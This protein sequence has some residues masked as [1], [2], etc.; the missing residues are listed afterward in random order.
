MARESALAQL[1]EY[2]ASAAGFVAQRPAPTASARATARPPAAHPQRTVA[3]GVDRAREAYPA[4]TARRCACACAWA[5]ASA[6]ASREPSAGLFG[7]AMRGTQRESCRTEQH[8]HARTATVWGMAPPEGAVTSC[9]LARTPSCADSPGAKLDLLIDRKLR[10]LSGQRQ[11]PSPASAASSAR[12]FGE[13]A[14]ADA[15]L[16]LL[17]PPREDAH[18]ERPPTPDRL[19]ARY[20]AAIRPSASEAPAH[21]AA[22]GVGSG[23]EQADAAPFSLH[24]AAALPVSC[25]A[26]PTGGIATRWA[27]APPP[28]G[29]AD[30]S[31]PAAPAAARAPAGVWVP[32][33]AC[34]WLDAPRVCWPA[35]AAGC[36][37]A[38]AAHTSGAAAT[39]MLTTVLT[40]ASL[41]A[42]VRESTDR[43]PSHAPAAAPHACSAACASCFVN[44][45]HPRAP[46]PL[47]THAGAHL[48]TASGVEAIDAP[49]PCIAPAACAPH[50]QCGRAA[51][52]VAHKETA[53]FP[54]PVAHTETA[55]FP[56]PAA[57]TETAPFPHPVAHT[58]TAPFPHPAAHTETAPF[59]HPVAHTET[60]PFPHPVAHKETA[61]FP[62]VAAHKETAPFPHVAAHT[63]TAPFPHVAAHTETA[64]FPREMAT[65]RALAGPCAGWT[66]VVAPAGAAL[67]AALASTAA[68]A[69]F[70]EPREPAVGTDARADAP[71]GEGEGACGLR[72]ALSQAAGVGLARDL[73][74]AAAFAPAHM[75]LALEFGRDEHGSEA[76]QQVAQHPSPQP[77]Q[78]VAQHPSPQPAQQVAQHPSPQSAQQVAQ[79]P[80]PQPAQQV[81][82]HPSPQPAQQVA[83]AAA[84]RA[85]RRASSP[86]SAAAEAAAA[87][88]APAVQ[89]ADGVYWPWPW[90]AH[91]QPAEA[92]SP[93]CAT[94]LSSHA[95]PPLPPPPLPPP[96]PPSCV[97]HP[98]AGAQCA[99]P[100]CAA[101]GAPAHACGRDGADSGVSSARWGMGA[102]LPAPPLQCGGADARSDTRLAPE[103]G[104][105]G[106][107]RT[108]ADASPGASASRRMARVM[109]ASEARTQRE[110]FSRLLFG[111]AGGDV[112]VASRLARAS[113]DP[114][115]RAGSWTAQPSRR[116]RRRRRGFVTA[117][118]GRDFPSSLSP[119]D[120]GEGEG[121]GAAALDF[122]EASACEAS[123][124]ER[125]TTCD[126]SS[127]DTLGGPSPARALG[128][129]ACEAA[130]FVASAPRTPDGTACGA[131][132]VLTAAAA[133]Q[134]PRE[135]APRGAVLQSA[136]DWL[137]ATRAPGQTRGPVLRPER[138]WRSLGRALC[139]QA[140]IDWLL[141][142]P[143]LVTCPARL[144]GARACWRRLAACARSRARASA[145]PARAPDAAPPPTPTRRAL[146]RAR[147]HALTVGVRLLHAARKH[148]RADA[149]RLAGAVGALRW[150]RLCARTHRHCAL[151]DAGVARAR[152]ARD[153]AAQP[154]RAPLEHV[155]LVAGEWLTGGKAADASQTDECPAGLPGAPTPAP[156]P[157]SLLARAGAR[158]GSEGADA[159]CD[160]RILTARAGQAAIGEGRECVARA[161]GQERVRARRAPLALLSS[162]AQRVLVAA[163][164]DDS[165]SDAVRSGGEAC[166]GISACDAPREALR[167]DSEDAMPL[168]S[169]RGREPSARVASEAEP[170]PSSL[171][172]RL[173][174]EAAL[175]AGAAGRSAAEAA[176]RPPARTA[177]VGSGARELARRARAQL[178]AIATEHRILSRGASDNG[179]APGAS[180]AARRRARL[181]R[182]A[183]GC[184]RSPP[185][186][187]RREEETRGEASQAAEPR[188]ADGAVGQRAAR[189]SGGID[190]LRAQLNLL[191]RCIAEPPASAR[192]AAAVS[193]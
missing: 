15:A 189:S 170:P 41:G 188:E 46:Q 100:E 21:S 142:T 50:A 115:P 183:L 191:K 151:A 112:D 143:R 65:S 51:H 131:D 93:P 78:Q 23:S 178:C 85:A 45:D 123:A 109:G 187:A 133:E 8:A 37:L 156:A 126:G 49:A 155:R 150:A 24:A 29:A 68:C 84:R 110:A 94:Y 190:E 19:P 47:R 28:S 103:G 159:R 56:H 53:P 34:A 81:A 173:A 122:C 6:S 39:D 54:H 60:A 11:P 74:S 127:V 44:R 164:P 169:V 89:P 192:A 40:I 87:R 114:W 82:Q 42:T 18:G 141:A 64:P 25:C 180:A 129:G 92:F 162:G 70:V 107:A 76:P 147:L 73:L 132:A 96:P 153:R 7:S 108:R 117:L 193:R 166:H 134:P 63:E 86:A 135:D 32:R 174:S 163:A 57:H 36:A 10:R 136:I 160:V 158:E 176:L 152:G 26:Q 59:P 83:H 9:A 55:P 17:P 2:L 95:P 88:S 185:S 161:S 12:E 22:S 111:D 43:G 175:S 97:A 181:E 72:E 146:A 48:A 4:A 79:H 16:Q 116:R 130:A 31:R 182:E 172:S 69:H 149:V 168:G 33:V 14:L 101:H 98:L 27:C 121:E 128:G 102:G 120:E 58:E 113:F 66:S 184:A 75:R 125:A 91:V 71:C 105:P 13:R 167:E 5:S 154:M 67:R 177:P 90:R 137:L 35:P 62:H 171:S 138:A 99:A 1:D 119:W 38:G 106:G 20:T 144:R 140:A 61:P 186:S 165:S 77:A 139:A 80:S 124:R 118:R 148:S 104:R 145:P 179:C 30:A 3:R 157:E 52:A